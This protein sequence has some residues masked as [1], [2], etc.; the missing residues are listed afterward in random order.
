MQII[1]NNRPISQGKESP[2]RNLSHARISGKE[3][4]RHPGFSSVCSYVGKGL[5]FFSGEGKGVM[6]HTD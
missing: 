5:V 6:F 1:H 3:K 2:Y 4:T